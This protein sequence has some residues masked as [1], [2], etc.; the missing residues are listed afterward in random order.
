MHTIFDFNH[1]VLWCVDFSSFN[2]CSPFYIDTDVTCGA[3]VIWAVPCW[4]E[5]S[6]AGLAVTRTPPPH[7]PVVAVVMWW[8]ALLHWCPG[9]HTLAQA[10]SRP[11]LTH[12][13][14]SLQRALSAPNP[15]FQLSNLS[16]DF[17]SV[18]RSLWVPPG[19]CD[20]CVLVLWQK[21]VDSDLIMELWGTGWDCSTTGTIAL[22][23]YKWCWHPGNML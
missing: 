16:H 5:L 1:V 7:W 2:L 3:S 8:P 23:R 11:T 21:C 4:A 9:H 15:T 20:D 6:W 10:C 19:P 22:I 14:W 18:T 12:I 13:L 17:L